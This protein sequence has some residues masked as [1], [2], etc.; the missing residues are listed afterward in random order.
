[1]TFLPEPFRNV[2]QYSS[3]AELRSVNVLNIKD[4][5]QAFVSGDE[6]GM[7][8]YDKTST[9]DDNGRSIIAPNN[10]GGRWIRVLSAYGG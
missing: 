6:A 8:W 7:F 9:F 5:T 2:D 3:I 1:M 4:R 10:G